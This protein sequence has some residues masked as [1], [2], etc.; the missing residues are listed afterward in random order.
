VTDEKDSAGDSEPAKKEDWFLVR[1]VAT[2]PPGE[3][4]ARTAETSNTTPPG[5]A[6]ANPIAGWVVGRFIEL[7]LPDQVREGTASAGIRPIAWFEI[8]RVAD[9]SGEK[10]QYLVAGA[11]GAEGQPCDFT[12]LRV[13]TWHVKKSRYETA[14]IENNLCGELPVRLAKSAK[15]EPEFRFREMGAKKDERGYRMTQT[16]VRRIR[17]DDGASL[18]HSAASK[19]PV[20]K[21]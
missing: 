4:A 19:K 17:Q 7:D 16:V 12:T 1:G 3:A 21:R 5:D 9:P 10:P 18:A 13:F 20:V 15:G 2:R 11:R 8:N 6:G 14:Y